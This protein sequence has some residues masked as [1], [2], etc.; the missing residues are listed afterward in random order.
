MEISKTQANGKITLAVEGKIG[1]TT[2]QQFQEAL[3]PAFDEANEVVLDFSG[4]TYIASA[5][6]RVLLM[7]QKTASSKNGS[8]TLNN[9]SEEVME[10]LDMTG[11]SDMLTIV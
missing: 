6:L 2:S 3:L 1:T 9:V 10:V 5:G 7:G 8:M 4:V 11:F